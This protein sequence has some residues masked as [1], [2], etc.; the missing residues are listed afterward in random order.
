M[1]RPL[2]VL[3]V[4]SIALAERVDRIAAIVNNELI[5]QSEVEKRAA[6]EL[7]RV[8]SEPNPARRQALRR[9]LLQKTLDG[10]IAEKL[11]ERELRDL[12]LEVSDSDI[13]LALEDV[14]KQNNLDDTQ[15]AAALGQEGYTVSS[16]REFMRKHL[17]KMKLINMK[18]RSKVNVTDEDVKAEYARYAKLESG[19]F[20]VRARHILVPLD[21]KATD[22]EI[23]KARKKAE[24]LREEALKPNVDF[25]KL[26]KEKSGGPSAAEGGDLGFFRR[27]VMVAE[28]EKAAFSLPEGGISEPI[29]TRFGWHVLKV[30]ER[31]GLPPRSFDEMKDSMRETL[32]KSQMERVT[33]QYLSDLRRGASVEVKWDAA[34]L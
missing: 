12:N 30:E 22:A 34:S 26:A 16:Y 31:R 25:A 20:E 24:S 21:A 14:K 8:S 27:G 3:L 10:L 15:F 4:S 2:V 32:F 11:M 17:S 7:T 19:D 1:K 29:R 18:V 33:D 13:D 28:F 23:E 5:A 6:L 9:E